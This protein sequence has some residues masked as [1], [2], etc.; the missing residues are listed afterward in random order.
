MGRADAFVIASPVQNP[1]M[2]DI[3]GV[4]AVELARLMGIEVTPSLTESDGAV[5][6]APVTCTSAPGARLFNSA[7][8]LSGVE[9]GSTG[10]DFKI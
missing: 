9:N 4:A 1:T 5:A 3:P 8:R 10:P 7:K 6:I 2:S